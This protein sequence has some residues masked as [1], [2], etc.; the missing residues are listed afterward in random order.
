M[1][2][3]LVE[4]V[5]AGNDHAFR[6]LIE[7]YKQTVY[8]TVFSVLRNQKDAEDVTYKSL[9]KSTLLFLNI[10]TKV[11]KLGLPELRSIMQSI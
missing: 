6:M 3:E 10:K 7:T 1:T 11:S 5:R 4:K 2:D 9:S 8:R